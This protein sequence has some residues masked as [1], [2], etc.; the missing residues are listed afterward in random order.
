MNH[1]SLLSFAEFSANPVLVELVVALN[2][3]VSTG[4]YVGVC[5]V[6]KDEGPGSYVFIIPV[7]QSDRTDRA[8]FEKL[9]TRLTEVAAAGGPRPEWLDL[10]TQGAY[11]AHGLRVPTEDMPSLTQMLSE[12]P[13]ARGWGSPKPTVDEYWRRVLGGGI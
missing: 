10:G 2:Q 11:D 3:Y 7:S 4:D 12:K 9:K 6:V 1:R 13:S 5:N 8:D